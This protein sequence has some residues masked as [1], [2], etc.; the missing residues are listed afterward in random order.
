M[1]TGRGIFNRRLREPVKIENMAD[2]GLKRPDVLKNLRPR[3][4]IGNGML[5]QG[6]KILRYRS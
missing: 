2:K 4:K 5:E 1:G 6:H 3:G